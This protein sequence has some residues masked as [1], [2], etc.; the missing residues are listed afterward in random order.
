MKELKKKVDKTNPMQ[1]RSEDVQDME[2]MLAKVKTKEAAEAPA[3]TQYARKIPRGMVAFFGKD[4]KGNDIEGF[5]TPAGAAAMKS[6]VESKGGTLTI[7]ANKETVNISH[8]LK[9]P[10]NK[11]GSKC[12]NCN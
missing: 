10:F 12:V 1:T 4:E 7:D 6:Y 9:R 3:P 5:Q 2:Q 8:R 11:N